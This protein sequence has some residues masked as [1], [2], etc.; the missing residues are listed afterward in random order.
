MI[1]VLYINLL[2]T[3]LPPV[4]ASVTPAAKTA[5]T[6]G[7][8]SL[9]TVTIGSYKYTITPEDLQLEQQAFEAGEGVRTCKNCTCRV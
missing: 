3:Q 2:P 7:G 8:S 5:R 4:E 9:R 1:A 6:D